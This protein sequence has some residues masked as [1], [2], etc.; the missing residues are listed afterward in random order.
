MYH[1]FK[2]EIFSRKWLLS[3]YICF[4]DL[5]NWFS[6]MTYWKTIK[7]TLIFFFEINLRNHKKIYKVV[8]KQKFCWNC[9]FI[10]SYTCVIYYFITYTGYFSDHGV[11]RTNLTKF[12][13]KQYTLNVYWL[14]ILDI[15][16]NMKFLF[17][18]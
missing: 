6:E 10:F 13:F 15:H 5:R 18:K 17:S 2:L 12:L 3:N 8:H 16:Q 11:V 4:S 1:R 14:N 7:F 9:D